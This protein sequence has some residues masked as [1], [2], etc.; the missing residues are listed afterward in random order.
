VEIPEISILFPLSTPSV[1]L[2]MASPH[3]SKSAVPK[4]VLS[5]CEVCTTVRKSLP[6][7]SLSITSFTVNKVKVTIV[8]FAS[9]GKSEV[10]KGVNNLSML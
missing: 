1:G 9:S 10:R 6:S 4:V 7:L 5:A 2:V 3:L 8:I